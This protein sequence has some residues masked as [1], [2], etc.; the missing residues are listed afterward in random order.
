MN[1][2]FF[3]KGVVGRS[4][5]G[6]VFCSLVLLASMATAI[7]LT[8]TSKDAESLSYTYLF[9]EPDLELTL[10][11]NQEYTRL[12]TEGCLAIG[13]SAGE[14]MMP[15]KPVSLLLPPMKEVSKINV[16]GT[17]VKLSGVNLEDNPVV[18]YQNPVPFGTE[19]GD[20]VIDESVYLINELYPGAAQENYQIGYSR[21]YTILSVNL[22]PVQYNP[23]KGEVYYY[24][25]IT[26]EIELKDATEMNEF[27]RNNRI[28]AGTI[29]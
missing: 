12:I 22:N 20:F 21:G 6:A 16:V 27:F 17:S 28:G 24:P 23:A 3:N 29:H 9:K 5:F 15:I 2:R 8:S 1:K 25:E 18:P 4:A 26:V 14:P 10:A 19:P 13:K 7:N 11:N